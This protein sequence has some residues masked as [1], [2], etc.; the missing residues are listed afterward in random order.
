M[1]GRGVVRAG[2]VRVAAGGGELLVQVVSGAM[3]DG[4]DQE[5]VADDKARWHT[6]KALSAA[7]HGNARPEPLNGDLN[8]EKP[9]AEVAKWQKK[10]AFDGIR[11]CRTGKKTRFGRGAWLCGQRTGRRTVAMRAVGSHLTD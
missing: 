5:E 1:V 10:H 4:G 8:T 7:G 6:Q 11:V 2:G 3:T 9:T